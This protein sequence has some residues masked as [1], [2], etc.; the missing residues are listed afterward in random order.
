MDVLC[1][2]QNRSMEENKEKE[3]APSLK[4]PEATAGKQKKYV[5]E[6][7]YFYFYRKGKVLEAKVT[8]MPGQCLPVP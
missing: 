3:V 6:P 4:E 8:A 5:K 7:S 1:H 2:A